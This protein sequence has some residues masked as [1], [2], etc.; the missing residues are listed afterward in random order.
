MWQ[1]SAEMAEKEGDAMLSL[2]EVV[3][4][5]CGAHGQ[6]VLPPVGTIIVGPCPE[7]QGLVV[8]FCGH[9][10]PLDKSIML[11][12]TVQQK[13]D[14]LLAIFT[15][16]LKDRIAQM[17]PDDTESMGNHSAPQVNVHDGG[18]ISDEEME[19]FRNLGLRGLD[20]PGYVRRH[21]S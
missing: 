10:L 9:I 14:H 16:F 5:H 7:C 8:V 6:I 15:E 12:G 19:T 21:L 13:R 20:D 11:D 2:I 4:P 1:T 18:P 17:I 3:C